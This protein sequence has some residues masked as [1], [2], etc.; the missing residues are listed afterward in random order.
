MKKNSIL[1]AICVLL[2]IMSVLVSG[3]KAETIGNEMNTKSDVHSKKDYSSIGYDDLG[4]GKNE[5]MITY[6]Y[7]NE[8]ATN[9]QIGFL[10]LSKK[11]PYV[12]T[13]DYRNGICVKGVIYGVDRLLK[14][15]KEKDYDLLDSFSSRSAYTVIDNDTIM[16]GD[17]YMDINERLKVPGTD[18]Y[19]YNEME[20]SDD[21]YRIERLCIPANIIDWEQYI[22]D[23]ELDVAWFNFK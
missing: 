9:P 1:Y 4:D 17:T 15:L 7:L 23:K 22:Y 6:F 13:L 10:F 5:G 21:P 8:D 19:C 12:E 18:Y 2:L 11:E 3:C 16:I 20:D 14:Y